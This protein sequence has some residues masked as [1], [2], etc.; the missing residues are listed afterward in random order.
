MT[1]LLP[2]L[3]HRAT[4]G[5]GIALGGLLAIA[6]HGWLRYRDG[7]ADGMASERT[8]RQHEAS[9]AK[10]AADSAWSVLYAASIRSRDAQRIAEKAAARAETRSRVAEAKLADAL[11]GYRADTSRR[12]PQCDEL[13][14]A[15][16]NAAALWGHERDTLT[17]LVAVQDT[18]IQ[19]QG[20][21]IAAEPQR[22][23]ASVMDALAQQRSTI[24]KPSRLTWASVGAVLG[25]I[26]TLGVMR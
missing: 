21:M 20:E 26:L 5:V 12:T 16:A 2:I 6:A 1:W 10:A 15:C 23:A 11:A 3:R 25:T 7:F 14:T 24:K 22:V 13:A 17:A 4:W 9:I 8:V 18:T 19:R